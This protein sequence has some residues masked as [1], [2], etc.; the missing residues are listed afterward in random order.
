MKKKKEIII[1]VSNLNIILDVFSVMCVIY[2]LLPYIFLFLSVWKFWVSLI[3][4]SLHR[5]WLA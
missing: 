5:V 1:I 2:F 4:V 3:L